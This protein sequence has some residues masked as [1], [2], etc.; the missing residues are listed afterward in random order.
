MIL[1]AVIFA[2]VAPATACHASRSAA[3]RGG[4]G[5]QH[6]MAKLPAPDEQT[7][8]NTLTVN[9][10]N[11][12]SYFLRSEKANPLHMLFVAAVLC[13]ALCLPEFATAATLGPDQ[14]ADTLVEELRSK[15]AEGREHGTPKLALTEK[16]WDQIA[17]QPVASPCDQ[18]G[19][20]AAQGC[21]G[22]ARMAQ[23]LLL[24]QTSVRKGHTSCL[25]QKSESGC[26][27]WSGILR[28]SYMANLMK[29]AK[30]GTGE[31]PTRICKWNYRLAGSVGLGGECSTSAECDEGMERAGV[32]AGSDSNPKN[33][34][35]CCG[36]ADRD[37]IDGG[38]WCKQNRCYQRC[39]EFT[40]QCRFCK[41]KGRR[42][43]SSR[44][45]NI[46]GYGCPQ[47]PTLA[48]H[49]ARPDTIVTGGMVADKDWSF[50]PP[51]KIPASD[52]YREVTDATKGGYHCCAAVR[53]KWGNWS[54]DS[55][56]FRPVDSV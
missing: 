47:Y 19:G 33:R 37:G 13:L 20:A 6:W 9:H 5:Y 30:V 35:F 12:R 49:R 32:E 54:P 29:L 18:L 10:T 43:P 50:Y 26:E 36:A 41:N 11:P 24:Y 3:A 45:C 51:K 8:S 40:V 48:G 46:E 23:I 4:E 15:L 34:V 31:V 42:L 2:I 14:T 44:R 38:G 56:A 53:L 1:K 52:C 22:N 55:L 21:K 39:P 25:T 27:A 16:Q 17:C 28:K 7:D